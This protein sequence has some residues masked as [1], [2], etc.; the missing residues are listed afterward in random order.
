VRHTRLALMA[1]VLVAGACDMPKFQGPQIQNPPPAFYMN[2][3]VTQTR[4]MFPDHAVIFHEAWVEASWGNFSGIYINGHPGN[5]DK[6]AVEAALGKAITDA[7]GELVEFGPMESLEVDGR[8]AWGWS[9]T[10]RMDD[11]LIRYGVFRAAIPYDTVTYAVDFLTGDPG[12]RNRPDS[13]RTV[14]AS[15]AVGR[16]EW[17]VPLLLVG[18]GALLFLLNL[19]RVR[20]K[21]RA[22]RARHVPLVTIPKRTRAQPAGAGQ[23]QA[24]GPPADSGPASR[25]PT[26]SPPAQPRAGA[27]DAPPS[28]VADAIRKR[29]GDQ[30]RGPA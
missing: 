9:E 7:Q 30:G 27:P 11:G 24:M 12:I 22:A 23:A 5:L 10:W 28:S 20:V 3:E 15:F 26:G 29:V 25:P 1:S 16:T 4:R 13:M 21:E 2:R 17:N 8:T 14:V 19:W 18:A 6:A